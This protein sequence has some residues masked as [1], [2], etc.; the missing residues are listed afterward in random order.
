MRKIVKKFCKQHFIITSGPRSWR[1]IGT[2]Q[3]TIRL[4]HTMQAALKQKFNNTSRLKYGN[5]FRCQVTV[6]W[7]FYTLASMAREKSTCRRTRERIL[8]RSC[9]RRVVFSS[10]FHKVPSQ[11]KEIPVLRS[12]SSGFIYYSVYWKRR[13]VFRQAIQSS[14]QCASRMLAWTMPTH[15]G[16]K[17]VAFFRIRSFVLLVC[18]IFPNSRLLSWAKATFKVIALFSASSFFGWM[19][20]SEQKQSA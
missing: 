11:G 7:D 9:F 16:W 6:T 18:G 12:F 19:R 10:E 13:S 2:V 1:A 15:R 3:R 17:S 5:I 8:Q 20:I 14:K 4:P